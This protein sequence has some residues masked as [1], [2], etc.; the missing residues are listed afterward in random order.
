M[1]LQVVAKHL[2][3]AGA[4]PHS[5]KGVRPCDTDHTQLNNYC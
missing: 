4:A 5:P 2:K 1:N 3:T